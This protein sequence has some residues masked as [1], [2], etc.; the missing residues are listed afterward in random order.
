M[1]DPSSASTVFSALLLC[2]CYATLGGLAYA[3]YLDF[4]NCAA[5]AE[6]CFSGIISKNLPGMKDTIASSLFHKAKATGAMFFMLMIVFSFQGFSF[7]TLAGTLAADS[8][9]GSLNSGMQHTELA[10]PKV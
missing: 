8:A 10:N 5:S 1:C 3:M 4:S 9:G 6:P 2:V 7:T